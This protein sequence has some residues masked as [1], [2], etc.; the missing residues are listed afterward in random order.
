MISEVRLEPVRG[1][2]PS[3]VDVEALDE[4]GG[5]CVA[6]NEPLNRSDISLLIMGRV[7]AISTMSSSLS[8][9]AGVWFCAGLA[10]VLSLLRPVNHLPSGSMVTCSV[11]SG[12]ESRISFTYLRY[13]SLG[14]FQAAGF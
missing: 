9:P 1:P 10:G 6:R 7:S 11:E 3:G 8:P 13:V 2:E 4:T 5:V 14:I 12:V